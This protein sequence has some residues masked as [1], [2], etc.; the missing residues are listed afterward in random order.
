MTVQLTPPRALPRPSIFSRLPLT[1]GLGAIT[2]VCGMLDAATFLGLGHVFAE[3]MNGN[4]VLLAFTVGAH[5]MHGF[6][7]LRAGDV[8]PYA[9]VLACFAAGAL[10]GGRLVRR[11]GETGRRIGF[12]SDAGLIGG[13]A[14]VVAL[15][16]PGPAGQARYLVIGILAVA[17]GLQNVLIR[18][19]GITDLATNAMTKTMAYLVAD[20]AL[21]GGDN[22]HAKRRGLSI[23]IFAVGAAVGAALSRYGV[24][25]PILASFILFVLALPIL[26]HPPG[27]PAATL[28]SAQPG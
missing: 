12:A 20:S 15:T 25:W 19:W 23:V 7:S 8:L 27:R 16:H 5:G 10:A 14:V 2:A 13:A 9:V 24:L 17:M 28:T 22:H 18:Q 1:A 6:T 3:T 11:D 26:L 4:I 21:G